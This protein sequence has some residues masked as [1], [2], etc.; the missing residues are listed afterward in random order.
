MPH[1]ELNQLYPWMS[2]PWKCENGCGTV[3]D[4]L[5]GYSS[6]KKNAKGEPLLICACCAAEEGH[7]DEEYEEHDGGPVCKRK[8][9]MP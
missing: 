2:N 5:E 1:L 8:R 3:F 7:R 4:M 9:S 6:Y